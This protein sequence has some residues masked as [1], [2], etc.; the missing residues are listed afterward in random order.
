MN[1]ETVTEFLDGYLRTQEIE[2]DCNNGLQVECETDIR[3]IGFSV[4]ASMELFNRGKT[5]ECQLLIVH[6]GL[7]WGGISYIRGYQY[8]RIRELLRNNIGLY[9]AHL[10]LDVHPE[11]GN[12]VVLARLLGL[13]ISGDF[14]T[15]KNVN[16]GLL[17]QTNVAREELI[18]RIKQ[19]VG[20]CTV[21][22]FGPDHVETVGVVTG[23]GM[24]ALESAAQSGCDTF[25]TGESKHASYHVAK[26]LKINVVYAGHYQ[27]ETLGVKALM[28]KVSAT[29]EAEPVFYDI[30]T[31][32]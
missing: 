17:C 15:Y 32:F 5:D 14:F 29:C 11:V 1:L 25:I 30:P 26:E 4:D 28:K 6:H 16:L 20:D 22:D 12:N 18:G 10:P 2:D 3:K 31:G 7:I 21:L 24:Q 27:T 19:E 23:S 9:A 8:R 13:K